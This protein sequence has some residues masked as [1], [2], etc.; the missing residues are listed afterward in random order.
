MFNIND[1]QELAKKRGIER[2][3]TPGKCL[4]DKYINTYTH[5]I[6]Q[7]G[8]CQHVWKARPKDIKLRSWCPKCAGNLKR[9]IEQMHEFAKIRGI[10]VTSIPGKCLSTEYIN[11]DTLLEWQCGRCNRI[12]QATP[13]NIKKGSWCPYCSLSKMESICRRYFEYIFD[14]TF[15]TLSPKWLVN[16]LTGAKMHLDGLNEYLKLAFEYNGI[17]HYKFN[18]LFHH[19]D[20]ECFIKQKQRDFTKRILC[21]ENGITLI[22]I[23]YTITPRSLLKH[24]FKAYENQTGIQITKDLTS[25]NF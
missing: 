16:P 8:K 15:P 9:T 21:K 2:T 6:W 11:I 22:V 5:L 3:G 23:P 1:M 13:N 25:K 17:Q 18:V 19:N 14:V 10:Q 7:C 20:Y 4:S 12:W 24:I